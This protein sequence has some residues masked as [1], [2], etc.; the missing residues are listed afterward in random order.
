[1]VRLKV[2]PCFR[3][4]GYEEFMEPVANRP[5]DAWHVIDD[6]KRFIINYV[7]DG[8]YNYLKHL[9]HSPKCRQLIGLDYNTILVWFSQLERARQR[10]FQHVGADQQGR[11]WSMSQNSNYTT[12]G[13]IE[14][15]TAVML[16]ANALE[17]LDAELARLEDRL[18]KLI[19]EMERAKEEI[20]NEIRKAKLM[21][22]IGFT[23]LITI[24]I[25]LRG[26]DKFYLSL[27]GSVYGHDARHRRCIG[28]FSNLFRSHRYSLIEKVL[29]SRP[30]HNRPQ[31]EVE[32][33]RRVGNCN[34]SNA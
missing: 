16:K 24:Q 8:F 29:F 14:A 2:C 7:S 20:R 33:P 26:T 10:F 30:L 4:S 27:L 19:Q 28:L 15:R 18:E 21:I 12:R 11:R 31:L 13:T 22:I 9:L 1:M 6:G 34:C 23:L 25:L 3:L 5:W 17:V 32:V